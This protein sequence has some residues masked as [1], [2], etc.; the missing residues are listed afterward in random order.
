[1]PVK[2]V[3]APRWL[4][5][6]NR[7]TVSS[8]R[9]GAPPFVFAEFLQRLLRDGSAL[10]AAPPVL[11]DGDRAAATAVLAAAFADAVLD[12]AGPPLGFE[13]SAALA[14][15][16]FVG[17]ACWFL[18]SRSEPAEMVERA[19]PLPPP[20][21]RP[22]A[23]LSADLTLRFL[24]ALHRRARALAVDDVLTR[25]L[26][27]TLREWPLSGAGADLTAPPLTAPDFAG[28]AGLL[29]LYAERLA[30]HPRPAWAP[31]GPARAYIEL[32]FAER[33]LRVPAEAVQEV[34]G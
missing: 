6:Y 23:H 25:A 16:E 10:L 19:L 34:A 32:V 15:A 13:A 31:A 20:P 7:V 30:L 24:P 5:C 21:P 28:H 22:A 4:A 33:G 18:V 1:M 26:E 27:R 3:S 8:R 14:A 2:S 17:R 11:Q 12:V 9:V 29:L